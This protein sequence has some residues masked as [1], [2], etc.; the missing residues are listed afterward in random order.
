MS[1]SDYD[2]IVT[3]NGS[4]D[5]SGQKLKQVHPAIILIPSDK[6]IGFTGGN[7]L[8]LQYSIKH[9]Y[10]YSILLN[11]DTFVE[12][13]FLAVLVDYLDE[14]TEVAAIQPKILFNHNR[15]IIWNGGSYYNKFLGYTYSKG[16]LRKQKKK[17]DT[18][19][20]VD[21]IT[22]CAFL[23]RNAVL[24]QTGL[25]AMNLF[26]YGEDTDLS[27]RIRQLGY[28]LMYHPASVI[29]HIAG[30]SNKNKT[31]GKEGYLN[32]VVHYLNERNK[33]WILKRYTPF[34][35]IPT[36]FI[37]NFFY[38]FGIMLYFVARLRF[39]KLKA[40]IKAVKDGISGNIEYDQTLS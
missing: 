20:E 14:H 9:H 7:N 32:P 19:K 13:D 34:Y 16:Y 5:G 38:S 24:E 11:N 39:K 28:K 12:K 26:I 30:M 27:F 31:K 23:V 10:T 18:I 2:I 3:D 17:D 33:I 4:E 35:Y 21:W 8:G 40:V 1:F 37:F 6:N 22:G 36:V 15:D 29:Y 25:L